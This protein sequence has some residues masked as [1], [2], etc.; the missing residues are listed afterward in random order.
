[1]WPIFL[2]AVYC[3]LIVAASLLG[4]WLPSIMRLSHTRMQAVMSFVGGLMAGVAIL[5]MWPHGVAEAD[6]VDVVAVATLLGLVVMFFMIRMFHVHQHGDFDP[7]HVDHGHSPK[8]AH[9]HDSECVEHDHHHQHYDACPQRTSGWIGLF[10]GLALHSMLDGIA[11]AASVAAAGHDAST[12]KLAGIGA[13]LA[14]LLHKPLD[15]LSIAI[16]MMHGGWAKGVRS[17]INA[18]FSLACPLGA[19]VF[20]LGVQQFSESQHMI[21]GCALGFAAGIF[22]CVSLADILPEVQF[23]SHDRLKLSFALVGGILLAFAIGLLEPAHTHSH[24]RPDA[25]SQQ[26]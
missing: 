23:H 10:M 14:V 8:E 7:D 2:L 22:L 5:H 24:S 17:A 12:V 13:F 21:V 1:M 9:Q 19:L 3:V 18:A 16:V 4:G 20:S 11:L 15:S 6:D 26:R 25:T